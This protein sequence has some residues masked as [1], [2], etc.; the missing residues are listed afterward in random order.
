MGSGTGAFNAVL[1]GRLGMTIKEVQ[2]AF[3]YLSK[4]VF[5]NHQNV[6]NRPWDSYTKNRIYLFD[7]VLLESTLKAII[8]ENTGSENTKMRAEGNQNRVNKTNKV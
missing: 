8:Q 4:T 6:K 5:A 1:L 2:R 7:S 3:V